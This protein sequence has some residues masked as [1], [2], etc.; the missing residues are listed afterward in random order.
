LFLQIYPLP[1]NSILIERHKKSRPKQK[2]LTPLNPLPPFGTII[3]Q[4]SG[5]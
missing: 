5:T 2:A 1:Q 3:R 4:S